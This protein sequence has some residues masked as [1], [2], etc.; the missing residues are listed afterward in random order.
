VGVADCMSNTSIVAL[1]V[2]EISA[3]RRTDGKTDM[4][5]GPDQEYIHFIGSETLPS[6]CYILS[7]ES[8]GILD[9]KRQIFYE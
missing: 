2:S 6:T 4:A 7:D 8:R 3:F 9:S 5:S 1:I